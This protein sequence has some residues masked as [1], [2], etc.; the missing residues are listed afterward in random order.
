MKKFYILGN[1]GHESG[2]TPLGLVVLA[3]DVSEAIRLAAAFA[4]G[5]EYAGPD[6]F[7]P[8][9]VSLVKRR[10]ATYSVEIS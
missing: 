5:V 2:T 10:G 8:T 9:D 1:L 7:D 4:R 6:T 3:H